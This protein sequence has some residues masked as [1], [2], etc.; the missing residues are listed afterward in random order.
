MLV[1]NFMCCSDVRAVIED[2][3]GTHENCKDVEV[4]PNTILLSTLTEVKIWGPNETSNRA[5]GQGRPSF[6]IFANLEFPMFY[7]RHMSPVP[8]AMYIS[9]EA[10]EFSHFMKSSQNQVNFLPNSSIR[11]DTPFDFSYLISG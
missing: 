8:S 5:S 4:A 9:S 10:I 3:A 1:I 7:T 6:Y 11:I 2:L